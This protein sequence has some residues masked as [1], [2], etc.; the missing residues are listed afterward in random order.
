[1]FI[2]YWICVW[3]CQSIQSPAVSDLCHAHTFSKCLPIVEPAPTTFGG[4]PGTSN[5]FRLCHST[6]VIGCHSQSP[7]TQSDKQ[8]N[9]ALC[10][11]PSV[12]QPCHEHA[13]R[14]TVTGQN[15]HQSHALSSV[16]RLALSLTA[17]TGR[18][19]K[20]GFSSRYELWSRRQ[21]YR[22]NMNQYHTISE[23]LHPFLLLCS[24]MGN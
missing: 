14:R 6:K 12:L 16:G 17:A 8:Q 7:V 5:I 3:A 19:R 13:Q 15:Q 9:F 4:M 10:C 2:D 1:M 11:L 22:Y 21:T 23:H 20:M 24:S 18:S